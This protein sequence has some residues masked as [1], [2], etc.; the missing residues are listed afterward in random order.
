MSLVIRKEKKEKER[1]KL[2]KLICKLFY[3][4]AKKIKSD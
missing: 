4:G 2:A 1:G 3:F